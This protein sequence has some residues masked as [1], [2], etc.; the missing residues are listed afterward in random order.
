[1]T[2]IDRDL[3]TGTNTQK[4]KGTGE[5]RRGEA[6]RDGWMAFPEV[7]LDFPPSVARV[8]GHEAV[9]Q[10]GRGALPNVHRASAR[11]IGTLRAAEVL[12][13]ATGHAG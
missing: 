11:L 9:H 12:C 6:H 7:V 13:A 8:Q 10:V 1:M 3:H 2:V 5:G 4:T